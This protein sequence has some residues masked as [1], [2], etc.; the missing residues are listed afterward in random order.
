MADPIRPRPKQ[1]RGM[2]VRPLIGSS[3]MDTQADPKLGPDLQAHIGRQL[4]SLYD[5][6]LKEPVPDRLRDLLQQLE[7]K[8]SGES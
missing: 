8:P 3:E 4:R 5:E 6:V 2:T 7:Q 1:K